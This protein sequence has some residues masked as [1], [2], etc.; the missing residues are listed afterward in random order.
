M[1]KTIAYEMS[2]RFLQTLRRGALPR[3][4][5]S[6]LL[7]G[8]MIVSSTGV[9][10]DWQAV[11]K[12]L[13]PYVE[14]SLEHDSNLLRVSNRNAL[15]QPVNTGQTSDTFRSLAVGMDGDL[16]ISKQRLLIGGRIYHNSYSRF[17]TLDHTAGSAYLRWK[18]V[19][20][21]LWSGDVGYNFDKKLRTFSNQETPV[22]DP[23]KRHRLYASASRWLTDRWRL[24]VGGQFADISFQ[25]TQTLDKQKSGGEIN[26]DYVTRAGN[27]VGLKAEVRDVTFDHVTT[28]DFQVYELGPTLDWRVG[29]K[30]RLLANLGYLS[31]EYDTDPTR[32]F[33]G[34]VGKL[35]GVWQLT[36]KTSLNASVWREISSLDDEVSDYAIIKGVSLEPTWNITPKTS[37]R[38]VASYEERDFSRREAD[39][40]PGLADRLDQLTTLGLWLDWKI[41]DNA[42]VSVGYSIDAR[43]SNRPQEEY[44]SKN[45]QA[46]V[47]VGF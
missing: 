24:G 45:L 41:R 34:L 6:F 2:V 39:V 21:R 29:G 27:S 19:V 40:V 13:H 15:G 36:G 18:W 7:L 44:E 33:D 43:D 25:K 10:A 38:A 9:A 30:L 32:D 1:E 47:R 31:Q 3:R 5:S 35:K 8:G 46:T 22:K 26:L 37:L 11:A 16:S 14:F 17:D 42:F 23:R 28:K 20:G 12:K 4:L